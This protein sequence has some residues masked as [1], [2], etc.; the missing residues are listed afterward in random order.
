M[1][2]KLGFLRQKRMYLQVSTGVS[3]CGPSSK[4]QLDHCQEQFFRLLNFR[5]VCFRLEPLCTKNHTMQ[6]VA[7]CVNTQGKVPIL[8]QI[9]NQ[10]WTTE[11]M[12]FDS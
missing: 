11:S 4:G 2:K 9:I 3:T 7:H 10:N 8:Y 5:I 1:R 6:N 12:Q